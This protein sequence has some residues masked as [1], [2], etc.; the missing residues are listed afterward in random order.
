M[1]HARFRLVLA[2]MALPVMILASMSAGAAEAKTTGAT[3]AITAAAE[4]TPAPAAADE[5]K[6]DKTK[7]GRLRFR[8]ADGTCACTCA[9]G[10]VSEADVRRAEELRASARN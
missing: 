6:P 3:S 4:T 5:A 1:K 9:K 8:S 2:S 10:G 7:S